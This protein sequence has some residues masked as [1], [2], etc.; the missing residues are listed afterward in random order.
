METDREHGEP[1]CIYA[2]AAADRA[3]PCEAG[4]RSVSDAT[5]LKVSQFVCL[6]VDMGASAVRAPGFVSLCRECL[7]VCVTADVR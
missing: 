3:L 4:S 6:G 7:R 2:L 1:G 5:E